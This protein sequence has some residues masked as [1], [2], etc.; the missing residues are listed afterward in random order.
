MVGTTLGRFHV[1]ERLGAGGMG[2]VY[3]AEDPVLG[4]RLAV[5]VLAPEFARDKE[6]RERLLHEAR[7]AS[8]LNH[9]NIVVVHDLGET[10]GNLWVAMERIEGETVRT[11]GTPRRPASEVVTLVRQAVAALD[12]AHAAGL[13]HRDLKPENMMVRSDGILKILDFGLARSVSPG[14]MSRTATMPGVILGTAPYMSP[15]QVL[16]QAAGPA[17]DLFSIGS[18]LYEL[19]TGVHPFAAATAVETMHRIL[20]DFPEPPSR[21]NSALTP[22]FDF[23]LNKLLA[24]E[25]SRRHASARDLDVDLETLECGC[26][27]AFAA[28]EKSATETKENG[29]R[30]I[31][32]LPFKNIGGDRELAYLGLGLADAVI[33]R[34]ST[35]RDLV[36]R[37]TSSIARYEGQPVDPRHVGQELDVSAV[38]DASYQRAGDRFRATAR[39]VETPGGR[40]LWAGKVEV[41]F[42]DIFDVQD[43]VAHGIAEALA[44][45]IAAPTAA[46]S[47]TPDPRA[48]ELILRAVKARDAATEEAF[49]EGLGYAEQ[50][51]AIQPEYAL[52]WA[53]LG[54]FCHGMVDGG[55]D[56]DPSWLERAEK[57]L[58]RALELDPKE[59]LALFNFGAF[60]LTRGKKREAWGTLLAAARLAPNNPMVYH[61]LGYLFRLASMMEEA[62]EC[63][64]HGAEID[65]SNPWLRFG[66]IRALVI[67]GRTEEA[68]AEIDRARSRFPGHPRLLAYEGH[69]ATADGRYEE[70]LEIGRRMKGGATL[71]DRLQEALLYAILGRADEARTASAGTE[72]SARIDMDN[73]ATYAAIFATLGEPDVAFDFLEQAAALGNDCLQMYRRSDHYGRLHGDPRWTPFLAGVERR[74]AVWK[75]IF[76][77]P[78]PAA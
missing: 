75:S 74:V 42:E 28:P 2:E 25:P 21:V 46:K 71:T 72:A 36:V 19:L 45:T 3:L 33:T 23:V 4:R 35:S 12:V 56:A 61:Y 13:V 24:K 30:A 47:F 31:A 63:D 54:G 53:T 64:R 49:R 68:R 65:P 8:A 38:L 5:K 11:W 22:D 34:L 60:T 10:D 70:A 52:A 40:A 26:L 48:Y 51:V 20:H 66:I 62:L 16:G 73:A 67:M 78:L 76:R 27:P 39:L 17:S 43:Q 18:I 59:A 7:A 15:E 37:A 44:A 55:F 50:A 9:P 58:R 77:W 57:A 69:C 41:R 29:P 1:L 6:R 14:T 32:V